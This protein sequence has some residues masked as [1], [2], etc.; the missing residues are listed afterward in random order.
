MNLKRLLTRIT[1]KEFYQT[2]NGKIFANLSSSIVFKFTNMLISFLMVPITLDYLDETRY[3]LWAALSSVLSWFFIFDIGIGNGL[4]NKYTELKAKGRIPEIR[5]YVS[6]AYLLFGMIALL[7]I[8]AF[9]IANFFIDWSSMLKAPASMG[10][11]LSETVAIVFAVMCVNFVLRLI[12]PILNADLKNAVV[13]GLSSL[14]HILTFVGVILLSKFTQ[15]SIIK[16]ALLYTG[17]NLAMTLAASVYLFTTTYKHISPSF[18]SIRF[19]LWNDL[20][21]VGLKFFLIQI[22]QMVFAHTTNFLVSNLLGPRYVTDYSINMRYF[23]MASMLFAM[24]V[25][26]LWSGYGDAYHRGDQRW[27]M[28]TFKRLLKLMAAVSAVLVMMIILQKPVFHIWLHGKIL[29]DYRLSTL[30]VIYYILTMIIQIYNPFIN[31]TSKLKLQMITCLPTA[32][33][34]LALAV[35]L[36]R[37]AGMGSEG[38]VISLILCRALPLAILTPLQAHKI[39]NGAKG[40]WAQ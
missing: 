5:Q 10:R 38:I 14:A 3:G 35:F 24:M 2:R 29:V 7:I 20:V 4:R 21:S 16:Y 40:I 27:I 32:A 31:S 11:E 23:T 28:I 18:R 25:H 34:F 22:S 39:L 1:G 36:I 12:N 30:M 15:P 9:V 19:N 17:S 33:L 8:I 26:P 6:T 37:V 13:D